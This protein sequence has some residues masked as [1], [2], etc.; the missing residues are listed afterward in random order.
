MT[1]RPPRTTQP[2]IAWYMSQ[3]HWGHVVIV[4]DQISAMRVAQAGITCVALLGNGMNLESVRDIAREKPKVV[5]LA[6]DPDAQGQAQSIAKKLGMYW[7]RIRVVELEAD[8]K[9]VS[10]DSLLEELAL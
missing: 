2:T 3:H 10:Y 5:T 8:P 7:D 1:Q 9:D 4:E 6:L